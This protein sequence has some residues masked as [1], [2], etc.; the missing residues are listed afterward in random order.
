MA[1]TRLLLLQLQ[2]GS[3]AP[4]HVPDLYRLKAPHWSPRPA[5]F[6]ARSALIWGTSVRERPRASH[7]SGRKSLCEPTALPDHSHCHW[8]VDRQHQQE[9]SWPAVCMMLSCRTHRA[10]QAT[11][12]V[13]VG[14][15]ARRRYTTVAPPPPLTDPFNLEHRFV[16]THREHFAQA[17]REIEAGRKLTHWS[18]CAHALPLVL[19]LASACAA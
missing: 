17:M 12:A 10:L 1:W 18:W 11:S 9:S 7:N 5:T 15:W 8:I 16:Q 3:W 2:F 6:E 13:G 14:A 19:P 4:L